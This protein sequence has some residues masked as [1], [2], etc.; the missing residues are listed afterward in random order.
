MC[1]RWYCPFNM[2]H[3]CAAPSDERC[4]YE[5]EDRAEDERWDDLGD[6]IFHQRQDEEM[7]HV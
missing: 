6:R 3:D 4:Q 7:L 1:E 5:D 2:S